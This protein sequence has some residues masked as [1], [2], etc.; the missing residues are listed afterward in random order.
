LTVG[1]PRYEAKGNTPDR[2]SPLEEL[3]TASR[4]AHLGRL[5]SLPW[6]ADE[7]RW[8]QESCE[9]N[10]LPV[11]R[12]VQETATEANVREHIR[13]RSLVHFACHG[14]A[15]NSYGNL[16]GALAL[17]PVDAGDPSDDGF[18]TVAEMFDLELDGCEL[19][20][21]SACDT[22]LGPN[23]RGEGTWSM[24]RGM[25]TSGARRVVT[26]DWQ[27]ADQASAHLVYS[28]VYYLHHSTAGQWDYAQSLRDARLSIRNHKEN[29]TW[30]HPYFWAPF[31]LV[32]PK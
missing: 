22:N 30:S 6:T 14:L 25:L 26:T 31:V 9:E 7:T 2:G 5:N 1:D 4:F 23:Q 21:L 10:D 20:I 11:V 27:V 17:T 32:G 16:F 18:L 8:I 24:C 28:L 19:A 3:Q 13:G 29:P 15:D 12:L